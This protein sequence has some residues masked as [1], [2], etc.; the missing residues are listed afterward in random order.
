MKNNLLISEQAPRIQKAPLREQA[1]QQIKELILT[2]QLRP[3]QKLSIGQLAGYLGVSQTPVR[4]ALAMLE[5]EGLVE[6]P[7]YGKPCVTSIEAKD[8]REVW[9]MR[10]LLEGAAID[11]ATSSLSSQELDELRR[12]LEGARRDAS[13][14]D[15][16][17]HYRSDLVLHRAILEC[18]HNDLFLELASQVEDRSVRIRTLVEAVANEGDVVTIVDEHLGL[19]EAL[20]TGD[21][22]A[23][24]ER[25][26]A[27]LEAG[28]ERTLAALDELRNGATAAR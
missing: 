2:N 10:L 17:A 14:S 24:R 1:A 26:L 11:K 3:G 12:D 9:D 25:L 18:V 19:V 27:H 6:M 28:R 5:P 13:A 4:E 22:D 20:R 16:R 7:P 23:A 21:K 15:Y 8:V